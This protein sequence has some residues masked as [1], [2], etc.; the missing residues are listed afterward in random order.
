MDSNAENKVTIHRL[1]YPAILAPEFVEEF[2]A[3]RAGRRDEISLSSVVETVSMI[4]SISEEASQ[5]VWHVFC[6]VTSVALSPLVL[7][8][9]EI[10]QAALVAGYLSES[11]S[12]IYPLFIFANHHKINTCERVFCKCMS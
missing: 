11:N 5:G 8:V 9:V 12:F 1:Q 3:V 6:E 10:R 7:L 4:L 2:P